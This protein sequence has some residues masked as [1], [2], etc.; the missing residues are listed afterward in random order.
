VNEGIEEVAGIIRHEEVFVERVM[1]GIKRLWAAKDEM[2]QQLRG[3]NP[4][5]GSSVD[6]LRR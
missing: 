5:A 2:V 1:V 6:W 3:R 4:S